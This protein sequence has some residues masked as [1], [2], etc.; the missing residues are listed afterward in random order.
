MA[1]FFC[2]YYIS[3]C[4]YRGQRIPKAKSAAVYVFGIFICLALRATIENKVYFT[5]VLG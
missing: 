5:R 3:V 2:V 4:V 1:C